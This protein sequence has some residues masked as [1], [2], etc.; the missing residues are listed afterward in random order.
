M[1]KESKFDTPEAKIALGVM[2]AIGII[3]IGVIILITQSVGDVKSSFEKTEAE[4]AAAAKQEKAEPPVAETYD[5]AISQTANGI[6]IVNN[7]DDNLVSCKVAVNADGFDTG[8]TIYSKGDV[9][10]PWASLTKDAERFDYSKYAVEDISVSR[11][12]DD[13]R[14]SLFEVQ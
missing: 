14:F 6:R 2:I 5:V 8:V 1:N 7:E 10:I 3:I 11:C 4:Q 9:F 12:N 13:Q